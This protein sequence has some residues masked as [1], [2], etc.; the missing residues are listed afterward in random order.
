MQTLS[1]KLVLQQSGCPSLYNEGGFVSKNIKKVKCINT[2]PLQT[3]NQ[4]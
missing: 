1:P 4:L 3:I 2:L